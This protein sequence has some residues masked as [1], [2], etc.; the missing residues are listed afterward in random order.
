MKLGKMKS[1]IFEL[2]KVFQREVWNMGIWCYCWNQN[3]DA[4]FIEK[5]T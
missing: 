4:V 1:K 2:F 5:I 3:I